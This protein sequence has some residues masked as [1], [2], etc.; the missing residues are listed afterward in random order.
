MNNNKGFLDA[1]NIVC[2]LF[3]EGSRFY[4]W[5]K[6]NDNLQKGQ[7][8]LAPVWY[9]KKNKWYLE[10]CNYN[11]E[12]EKNS[13]WY[14]KKFT[15]YVSHGL[16]VKKYFQLELDENLLATHCKERPVLLINKFES[17]WFCP[18][19]SYHISK[20]WLCL[21]VFTYK[22][23]HN[24]NYVLEDQKFNVNA[25]IYLPS[26]CP[27]I[28]NE[29]AIQLH[30]LQSINEEYLKPLTKMCDEYDPK[31]KRPYK[32]CELGMNVIISH[33]IKYYGSLNFI[34]NST[35]DY[36]NIKENYDNFVELV[37]ETI[38]EALK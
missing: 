27:G 11:I 24:Q 9:E 33:L 13:T 20:T 21:P 26:G 8:C 3:N 2:D 4:E 5:I 23:R 30:T 19:N 31:M 38:N 16:Y 15:N 17:D 29:S 18:S 35:V 14:A 32:I 1:Y 6:K 37:R 10:E 34:T 12:D 22:E 25:R 36:N 7:L 28:D